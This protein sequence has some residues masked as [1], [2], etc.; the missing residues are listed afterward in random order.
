LFFATRNDYVAAS[1]RQRFLAA[2]RTKPECAADHGGRQLAC[3]VE[4]LSAEPTMS[5]GT[6]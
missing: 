1:K 3:T 5:G 6:A 2:I 4:P